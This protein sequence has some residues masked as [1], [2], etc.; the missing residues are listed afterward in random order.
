MADQRGMERRTWL[1]LAAGFALAGPALAQD[2][3]PDD[4]LQPVPADEYAEFPTWRP[5]RAFVGAGDD[6]VDLGRF[7]PPVRHQRGNSCGGW[8]VAYAAKSCLEAQ[9]RGWQPDR[10]ERQFSPYYLYN[11][12]NGGRDAGITL[13]AALR[14]MV[15]QGCATLAT[16]PLDVGVYRSPGR[17]ARDEAAR[18]P[19]RQWFRING[20][21]AYGEALRH[22][23]PVILSIRSFPRLKRD[24]FV[25][26][27]RDDLKT[28]QQREDAGGDGLGRHAVCVVGYSEQKQA[29]R[30]MNSWGTDSHDEGF[31]WIPYWA[32]ADAGPTSQGLIRESYVLV[33]TPDGHATPTRNL[34]LRQSSAPD[35]QT[36]SR[37]WWQWRAVL[38]G[39][40]EQLAQVVGMTFHAQP[41]FTQDLEAN[42]AAEGWTVGA[43]VFG[44][45]PFQVTVKFADGSS[46]VLRSEVELGEP[47]LPELGL[48]NSARDIGRG[49]FD[50]TI[51]LTGSDADLQ[52]VD[53]V[54]YHLH[55][56]FPD[57]DRRVDGPWRGGFALS[58]NGWGEFEITAEVVLIDGRTMALK[59]RL[60]FPR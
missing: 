48:R 59:H 20:A 37:R 40:A 34:R 55:P 44:C 12:L 10:P 38:T 7:L 60:V 19:C 29:F 41:Y 14:L 36:G 46:E 21:A 1:G 35:G 52:R 30:V 8:A 42:H 26:F 4:G 56:T 23:L 13:A 5:T 57:P 33:D 45:F 54:T 32:V 53:H 49:R 18:Y 22:G 43:R 25:T 47:S 15:D 51:R 17:E 31:F 28:I 11:Q 24:D 9:D 39:P 2:P 3:R 50:W 58:S 27:S 6:G 16:M